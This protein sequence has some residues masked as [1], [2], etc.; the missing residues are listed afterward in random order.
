MTTQQALDDHKKRY[1]ELLIKLGVNLQAGQCLW[2]TTELAHR[3][4]ARL[5]VEA[6]YAAGAKYV[7]VDWSDPVSNKYRF[8]LSTPE[9]LEYVPEW[10]LAL[11]RQMV[12]E[13]WAR[14]VI[15]GEEYPNLMDDV[16]PVRMRRAAVARSQQLKFYAE[17]QMSN[18]IQW[19][20]SAA[21][22]ANWAHKMF[23]SLPEQEAVQKLWEVILHTV[24]V[25][26]P[27]PLQAWR[28]H[29]T[30][31]NRIVDFLA[32][33]K[34]HAVRFFDRTLAA[35]GKPSS[36]LT[37]GLTNAPVWIA[38][39]SQTPAGVDFLPNMPTEE[40]FSTPHRMRI[41][42]YVR[43][44]KP[45][46]PLGRE[47]DKAFFRFEHGTL[48]EYKA[49]KGEEVL[50]QFFEIEGARYLGEVALVDVRSPINQC[51]V[52]FYNTL[53]DENAVCHIAF[54]KAY[55]DGMQGAVDMSDEQRA[56]AGINESFTHSDLMIG[57]P[58]MAVYGL[59]E[60]GSQVTIMEDGQFVQR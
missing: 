42:G 13:A 54:G 58:T 40:V 9:N 23:P 32:A 27:D 46:F 56:E 34:I 29:G 5:A 8:T 38:A 45:G 2:I 53:F 59:H 51:G 14:L 60:D 50:M 12:D 28:D 15:A 17:A 39:G 19:C 37:I 7:H 55:P 57:T 33:S 26:Q 25:D 1:A 4:F 24:R 18:Q 35:D 30:R 20:V 22:T 41:D 3:E 49:E 48:V 44:S 16:D 52:L 31:L 43:T 10:Q 11:F 36:D 47:V 6:A 21:P